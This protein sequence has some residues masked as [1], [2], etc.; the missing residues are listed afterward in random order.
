MAARYRILSLI[1]LL[2]IAQSLTVNRPLSAEDQWVVYEGKSGPGMGKHI[3]LVSGDEE[4]RSEEA[5]PQLGKILATRH[6]FKCT[7]LFAINP[8]TDII[9]PNYVENIPGLEALDSADLMILSTRMR[10]LPGDQMQHVDAYLKSGKPIIGLRTATHA[11]NHS[12]GEWAH[13][14]FRHKSNDEWNQGFGRLVLG[15]TWINH[16]GKHKEE[17]T[18]GVI[19]PDTAGH[20]ILTGISNGDIWG[21]TDVYGVRLPLPDDSQQLVLGQV[22]LR[23]GERDNDD[24]NYGMRPTDSKPAAGGKNDPMMPVAWTKSYQLP[25]GSP[26]TAFTTTMGSSTDLESKGVRRM[27]VNAAY[28]LLDMDIPANGTKVGIV[29]DY[30]PTKFEFRRGDYWPT[31]KMKVSEHKM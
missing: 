4:Y 7:V 22:T 30:Q 3:V 2:S 23:D 26:G 24:V 28:W 10:I 20:P 19:P 13:Y 15:E 21:S 14:G 12:E 31:R 16:H 6:G 5:L 1:C 8:E 29:G 9:D 11:F 27:I 18:L 25:D 17:S